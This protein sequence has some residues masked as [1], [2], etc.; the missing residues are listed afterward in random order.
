MLPPDEFSTDAQRRFGAARYVVN[1]AR[2]LRMVRMAWGRGC[3]K[4]MCGLAAG[5]VL[6]S[7]LIG[8]WWSR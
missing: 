2:N 4:C 5:L 7:I 1:R 6:A 3:V 8:V